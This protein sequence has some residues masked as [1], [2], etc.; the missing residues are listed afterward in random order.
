MNITVRIIYFICVDKSQDMAKVKIVT[1]PNSSFL[2]ED[3]SFECSSS[4]QLSGNVSDQ[5]K[6][7]RNAKHPQKKELRE[8]KGTEKEQEITKS[9]G[10][11]NI[12][13]NDIE[14]TDEEK[15]E[16][17]YVFAS[18]G[19]ASVSATILNEPSNFMVG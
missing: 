11:R 7:S 10:T 5:N 2:Q 8:K 16:G 17:T 9:D 6:R 13:D 14:Y 15:E 19:N 4:Q 3:E 18:S 1:S 12:Q